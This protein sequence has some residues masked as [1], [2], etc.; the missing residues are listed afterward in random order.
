[1]NV[2]EIIAFATALIFMVVFGTKMILFL[3]LDFRND[4]PLGLS[5]SSLEYLSEYNKDVKPKDVRLK[6]L[7]NKVHVFVKYSFYLCL[8]SSLLW[9]TVGRSSESKQTKRS[10]PQIFDELTYH[11]EPIEKGSTRVSIEINADRRVK[12]DRSVYSNGVL[13][14]AYSGVFLGTVNEKDFGNLLKTLK[15]T[16]IESYSKI[17]GACDGTPVTLLIIMDHNLHRFKYGDCLENK[18]MLAAWLNNYALSVQLPRAQNALDF[19]T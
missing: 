11:Y 15:E 8:M 17:N 13:D 7:L 1:M 5:G 12:L 18:T 19:G 14:S 10:G 16:S 2:F 6:A 4:Y 9:L 3:I